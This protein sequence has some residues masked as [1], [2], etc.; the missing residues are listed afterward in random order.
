MHQS[1]Y[2]P[3]H[4]KCTNHCITY[5]HTR[6]RIYIIIHTHIHINT[7]RDE[8]MLFLYIRSLLVKTGIKGMQF[9][10]CFAM[11]VCKIANQF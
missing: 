5:A 6:S 10:V 1:A 8:N 4:K 7:L 3:I 2:W 9:Y 11:N